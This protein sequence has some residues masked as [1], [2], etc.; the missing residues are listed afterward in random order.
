[1]ANTERCSL[2]HLCRYF[3]K[4]GATGF[5]GPIALVGYMQRDLV[6]DR[7][8][9]SKEEFL[10]GVALSQLI[11]GPVASQ[12]AMY[13]G[14]LRFGI[15]GATAVGVT[16]ILPSFLI[17][18]ALAWAYVHY[19]NFSW[20][21]A[22]FIGM[23]A[24]VVS[25]IFRS[26]YKL[27]KLSVDKDLGLIALFVIAIF[28]AFSMK[29]SLALFFIA[30]GLIHG[31]RKKRTRSSLK[32]IPAGALL[33]GTFPAIISA[34]APLSTSM[35]P[36]LFFFFF[37]AGALVFGSGLVIIPLLYGGLVHDYHWLTDQQFL[38]AVAIA[39]V[40]PGP[41]LITVAF[42]GYLVMGMGGATISTIGIFLPV[43]L[44]VLILG[45]L[46]QRVKHNEHL[47]HFVKGVTAVASGAIVG[48][49]L[50]VAKGAIFDLKTF[51]IAL[52]A[53]VAITKIKKLPEALVI[54]AAGLVGI[55][56]R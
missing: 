21:H 8:W 18:M 33:S 41:A 29:S 56:F 34:T 40:T 24:A 37:K 2:L 54:L 25:I 48:S 30:G 27:T 6:E 22:F 20:V 16:F 42:I 46:F 45:N 28:A 4:L 43:Y 23:N 9:F 36:K 26:A 13:L 32:N 52:I 10:D 55:L 5:G 12:L 47:R 49:A 19:A 39:M 51:L 17:V 38:D 15:T 50:I 11:P 44:Y 35:L 1:M 3:L 14:Y 31:W 53:F 7:Q